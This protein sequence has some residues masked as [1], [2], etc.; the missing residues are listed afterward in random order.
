MFF[1]EVLRQPRGDKTKNTLCRE[2]I[3]PTGELQ[4]A[5]PA[6]FETRPA[7]VHAVIVCSNCI[8]EP[9]SES[10]FQKALCE[11]NKNC[12]ALPNVVCPPKKRT[13]IIAQKAHNYYSYSTENHRSVGAAIIDILEKTHFCYG[14]MDDADS[15]SGQIAGEEK[16]NKTDWECIW[17]Q[18]LARM[19]SREIKTTIESARGKMRIYP[20]LFLL[21]RLPEQCFEIFEKSKFF[22]SYVEYVVKGV[23]DGKRKEIERAELEYHESAEK[24]KLDQTGTASINSTVIAEE[25]EK[26][27]SR[28][29]KDSNEELAR[30]IAQLAAIID[31]FSNKEINNNDNELLSKVR[32][33]LFY[34]M[35]IRIILDDHQQY[36]SGQIKSKTQRPPTTH[37]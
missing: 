35:L 27:V 6:F 22:P 7:N 20:S 36:T 17:T 1:T 21:L 13:T 28:S 18:Q 8:N 10:A 24:K 23:D 25:M 31:S 32:D 16:Y 3:M 11:K 2:Y 12:I 26:I 4:Q 37:R 29:R 5:I 9:I 19:L 33:D 30:A 14:D 15:L 34:S